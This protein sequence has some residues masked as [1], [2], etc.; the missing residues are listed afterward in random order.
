MSTLRVGRL[1]GDER[2]SAS[3]GGLQG[4]LPSL[5][6]VPELGGTTALAVE[7]AIRRAEFTSNLALRLALNQ[8][9]AYGHALWAQLCEAIGASAAAAWIESPDPILEVLLDKDVAPLA[10]E[11][12]L[13]ADNDAAWFCLGGNVLRRHVRRE[14]KPVSQAHGSEDLLIL[15]ARPYLDQD[16]RLDVVAGHIP[17]DGINFRWLPNATRNSLRGR[18][19]STPR[20]LHLDMHG[21]LVGPSADRPFDGPRSIF[22]LNGE[23]GPDLM[24]PGSSSQRWATSILVS[25]SRRRAKPLC[26]PLGLTYSPCRILRQRRRAHRSWQ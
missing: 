15:S 10:W 4:P 23:H 21:L 12:L 19:I 18:P 13:P 1:K 25:S 6:T 9:R 26:R 16:V 14:L 2:L 20:L 24:S 17:A 8:A 22:L 11:L 3:Y 5:A 7:A